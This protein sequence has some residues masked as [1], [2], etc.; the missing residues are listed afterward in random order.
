VARAFV[1]CLMR[2]RDGRQFSDGDSTE[3]QMD[4][5]VTASTDSRKVAGFAVLFSFGQE[6]FK[7]RICAAWLPAGSQALK[8]RDFK[9][10]FGQQRHLPQAS[11][12]GSGANA[13]L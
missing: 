13:A 1:A 8:I 9:A 10:Q 4:A 2:H 6:V 7:R 11:L 5:G 12:A 3:A